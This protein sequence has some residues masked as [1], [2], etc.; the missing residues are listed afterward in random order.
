V[1][2]ATKTIKDKKYP[3][4]FGN[5]YS[6]TDAEMMERC[7]SCPHFRRCEKGSPNDLVICSSITINR[8]EKIRVLMSFFGL[9][10][11]EATAELVDSGDIKHL[12]VIRKKRETEVKSI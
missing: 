12:T 1:G 4:C 11:A 7:L 3:P 9:T 10:R 6:L 8:E 5:M 2:T